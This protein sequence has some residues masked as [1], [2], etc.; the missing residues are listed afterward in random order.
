MISTRLSRTCLSVTIAGLMLNAYFSPVLAQDHNK[1]DYHY[2]LRFNALDKPTT[3]WIC[4][5]NLQRDKFQLPTGARWLENGSTE[6]AQADEICFRYQLPAKLPEKDDYFGPAKSDRVRVSS[7]EELIP[8]ANSKSPIQADI[9]V[10]TPAAFDVSLPGKKLAN[11]HFLLLPRPCDWSSAIIWGDIDN[12]SLIEN[13]SGNSLRVTMP[14]RISAEQRAKLLHWLNAGIDSLKMTHGKLP[15]E[16]IQILVFPVGPNDEIVPWG[17]VTRGGGDAVHLYVDE[18]RSLETL[19]SDWVLVHELSHL[20]HPYMVGA[21]GWLSEGIASYYQNVL[22]A[23]SGLL[24]KEMAWEKLDAG[25]RRGEKQFK[26]GVRLFENTR[27]MMRDR[28]YMR[29]Y[30][31]GAA[32]AM[33]GDVQLRQATNGEQSLDTL[34]REISDC[35]LPTT[36]R[37]WRAEDLIQRFDQ[38]SGTSIFANLYD[39]YVMHPSFPALEQAYDSLGLTRQTKG[40][41]FSRTGRDLREAIMQGMN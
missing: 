8:C 12:T 9:F 19:N 24:D 35:C 11:N 40:L 17:Q 28:Q 15:V 1:S 18:T 39:S 4:G 26:P 7:I 32:I 30:W 3:G 2:H 41:S 38:I 16:D 29:V 23:R 14:K 36:L 10:E 20:L 34:L 21:D 22:R 25:F 33:L 37:K 13:D 31:S 27:Q 5:G 6:K